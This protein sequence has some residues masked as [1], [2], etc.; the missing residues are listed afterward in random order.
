MELLAVIIIMS[1]IAIIVVPILSDTISN[2]KRDTFE[3]TV[4]A[5]VREMRNYASKK[6]M[7]TG[8]PFENQV[9][10]VTSSELEYKGNRT[11][12]EG[13]VFI[14]ANGRVAIEMNN[15]KYC[16]RKSTSDAS[17]EVTKLRNQVCDGSSLV[18][19]SGD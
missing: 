14:D 17:V 9:L 5:I 13:K 12:F 18:P 7:E 10:D 15:G 6:E 11:D 4:E 19:G 3:E 1:L 8:F 2:A 16:A